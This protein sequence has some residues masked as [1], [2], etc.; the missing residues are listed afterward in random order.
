M[1]HDEEQVS[2]LSQARRV[3]RGGWE[4]SPGTSSFPFPSD[5]GCNAPVPGIWDPGLGLD[6]VWWG[7]RSYSGP[8]LGH[9]LCQPWMWKSDNLRHFE[10]L[11]GCD[12][13][14]RLVTHSPRI[15]LLSFQSPHSRCNSSSLTA[16]FLGWASCRGCPV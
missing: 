14:A 9:D 3:R 8:G 1:L 6:S 7:A 5:G 15:V 11:D 13:S 2:G 12:M 16:T 4:G 10:R